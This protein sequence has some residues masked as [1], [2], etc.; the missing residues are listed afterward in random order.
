MTAGSEYIAHSSERSKEAQRLLGRLE[1]P[2]GAL[3]LTV[4]WCEFSARLFSPLCRL[5]RRCSVVGNT[6]RM[7]GGELANLS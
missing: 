6:R 4:G 7:A 1:P 3:T 5:C 2:H